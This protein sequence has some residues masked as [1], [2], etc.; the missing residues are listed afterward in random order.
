M[1][2]LTACGEKSKGS[3]HKMAVQPAKREIPTKFIRIFL[4]ESKLQSPCRSPRKVRKGFHGE[5]L[6]H[7]SGSV[8]CLLYCLILRH[9]LG[10]TYPAYRHLGVYGSFAACGRRSPH[11]H[12]DEPRMLHRTFPCCRVGVEHDNVHACHIETVKAAGGS[13][14]SRSAVKHSSLRCF[15]V[16]PSSRGCKRER[17]TSSH[18]TID[19]LSPTL[20]LDVICSFTRPTCCRNRRCRTTLTG[21]ISALARL[22]P[23]RLPLPPRLHSAASLSTTRA[24]RR[25]QQPPLH[26]RLPGS[27][28]RRR[29]PPL[30]SPWQERPWSRGR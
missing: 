2:P 16:C 17:E 27:S 9:V 5:P 14:H 7:N 3:I 18:K 20:G 19:P 22:P 21:C 26:P 6:S 4:F 13:E 10:S 28:I 15:V 24:F 29:T 25:A 30:H 1:P 8:L 23:P 12:L 11:P